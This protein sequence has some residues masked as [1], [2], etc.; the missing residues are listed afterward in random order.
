ML[1]IVIE[2]CSVVAQCCC[3]VAVSVVASVVPAL[4]PYSCSVD[5]VLTTRVGQYGRSVDTAFHTVWRPCLDSIGRRLR[6]N[7]GA[8]LLMGMVQSLG[9]MAIARR[10]RDANSNA[11][12][13]GNNAN[14]TLSAISVARQALATTLT[15]MI[16]LL[17]QYWTST[18]TVMR[19]HRDY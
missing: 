6:G 9:A 12:G 18:E 5:A 11:N 10:A 15:T 17:G 16:S 14:C 19:P 2:V 7:V 1:D 8:A 4:W 3:I 13:T